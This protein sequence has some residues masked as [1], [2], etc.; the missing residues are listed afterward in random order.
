MS[1]NKLCNA[2]ISLLL[3]PVLVTAHT[4]LAQYAG[5]PGVAPPLPVP[6][7]LE[8]EIL[9]PAVDVSGLDGLSDSDLARAASADDGDRIFIGADGLVSVYRFDSSRFGSV[10]LFAGPWGFNS[11]YADNVALVEE[12]SPSG[13]FFAV[14]ADGTGAVRGPVY[15]VDLATGER[16]RTTPGTVLECSGWVTGSDCLFI[17][18]CDDSPETERLWQEDLVG[19][20]PWIDSSF[21]TEVM[22][23][24][25][26]MVVWRGF[27]SWDVLPEDGLYR[28]R[29][30]GTPGETSGV[31]VFDVCASACVVPALAGLDSREEV[32]AWVDS[33][34][35]GGAFPEYAFRVLV[36]CDSWSVTG[37]LPM[38]ACAAAD[39]FMNSMSAG[40][41]HGLVDYASP[42][43]RIDLLDGDGEAARI[44]DSCRGCGYRIC[45][46]SAGEEASEVVFVVQA[47]AFG[48]VCRLGLAK[49]RRWSVDRI[50]FEGGVQP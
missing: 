24:T 42:E 31:L 34:G 15:V 35:Y 9:S 29:P 17:E 25:S 1:G 50:E 30:I 12:P 21:G 10:Y 41:I 18:S 23:S 33:A 38:D 14:G 36:D 2:G 45:G 49:D 47:A 7:E 37:I 28:Y 27:E 26:D 32:M 22:F 13:R 4:V 20:I 44:A 40:D 16:Y 3:V 48:G 6:V 43:L 39:G 19:S 8:V 11:V 5:I 46:D